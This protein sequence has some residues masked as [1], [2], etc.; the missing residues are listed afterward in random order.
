MATPVRATLPAMLALLRLQ[1]RVSRPLSAAVVAA[2]VLNGLLGPATVL[3]TG[4]VAGAVSA[5]QGVVLAVVLLGAAFAAQRLLEPIQSELA[6]ALTDKVQESL[7]DRVTAVLADPPGLAHL[8]D[9]A[10]LD[11][12]ARAQGAMSGSSPARA[13]GALAGTIGSRLRA[14]LSLAIVGAWHWWALFPLI[15]AYSVS[16]AASR[17]HWQQVT[18][19]IYGRTEALRRSYYLRGL[20]LGARAAKETRVFGLAGWLVDRYRDRW[21]A[22][23]REVWGKRREGWL[24]ALGVFLLLGAVELGLLLLAGREAVS[25]RIGAGQI[26]TLIGALAGASLFA[27]FSDGQYQFS[28]AITALG[29]LESLET[30]AARSSGVTGGSGEPGQRP[31]VAIRFEQVGFTYPGR[32]RPVFEGLD[33]EL[34][35]G[36]SLAVVGENGAGKTT[37]VKLLA[38]LYDPQSGRITVDG[39]D[40]RQLEPRAWQRRVAAVFQ[41]FTRFELSAH[42]NVAFGAIE[43]QGDRSAVERAAERAGAAA[44]IARLPGG[45]DTPLS[46]ELEG[47]AELSEGEWQRLALARALRAV[48]AGAGVLVLDE[49]TASLD[50]R[51]EAEVYERF[52]ELTRGVTTIVISHRFSTVRRADRIVVLEE[53]RV[54]EDGS[55]DQLVQAG[56]RYA[57]MYRLQAARFGAEG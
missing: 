55:H 20:A 43:Q 51:G 13:T 5:G 17:W 1:A 30:A 35:A 57:T 4:A 6:T 50:V 31:R 28:Q 21:L 14:G 52:L 56:G 8:E 18:Q 11:G 54:I 37:F 49:P 53:G 36:R 23:M 2:A 40:L 22:V 44:V 34:E 29:E 26:V 9:P 47:G 32:E 16:Y 48:E 41:D 45:W 7:D 12:V 15:A 39:V 33:L 10:V 42:D 19:V 46:R 25:G 24:A 3:A 27:E 38:R